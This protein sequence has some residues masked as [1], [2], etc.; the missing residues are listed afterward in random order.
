MLVTWLIVAG[1]MLVCGLAMA[2]MMW[3]MQGRPPLRKPRD[4]EPEGG[5]TPDA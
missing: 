1:L 4:K 5:R 2:R 3:N